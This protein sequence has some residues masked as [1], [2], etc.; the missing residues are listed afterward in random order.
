MKKC[1]FAVVL[2]LCF[3]ACDGL[4]DDDPK[5]YTTQCKGKEQCEKECDEGNGAACYRSSSFVFFKKDGYNFDKKSCDLKYA[6]G[7]YELADVIEEQDGVEKAKKY[8]KKVFKMLEKSCEN[9]HNGESCSKLAGIHI[10]G[11]WIEKDESKAEF[12]HKKGCEFDYGRACLDLG[13]M[14]F[15][16]KGVARDI[17]KALSY[18]QKVASLLKQSCE[19][20]LNYEN[21]CKRLGDMYYEGEGVEKDGE[22]ALNYHQ[23]ACDLETSGCYYIGEFYYKI[24][25]YQKAVSFYKQNCDKGAVGGCEKLGYMYFYGKGVKQDF[26]KA[27]EY[28]KK[29]GYYMDDKGYSVDDEYIKKKRYNEAKYFMEKNAEVIVLIEAWKTITIK[30]I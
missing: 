4:R 14:Y 24:K 21:S 7:C 30:T 23:K 22:K 13:N 8:R 12:Y 3:C 2:A 10:D 29:S 18:H 17:E 27:F 16:G 6:L 25:E 28:H 26:S 11:E 15:K 5:E 9:N 19:D 1:L 20:T